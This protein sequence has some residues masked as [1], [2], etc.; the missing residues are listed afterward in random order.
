MAVGGGASGGVDL[1]VSTSKCRPRSVDLEA[2]T[3]KRRPR[4]VDL[5][6]STS[7][8]RPRSVTVNLW[9]SASIDLRMFTYLLPCDN[10]KD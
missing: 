3:S 8:R 6:A 2:S 5:E 10:S 9:L 4:S 1:K 7:K